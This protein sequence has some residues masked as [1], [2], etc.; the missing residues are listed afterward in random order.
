MC[1]SAAATLLMLCCFCLW[2]CCESRDLEKGSIRMNSQGATTFLAGSV[3]MVMPQVPSAVV[4]DGVERSRRLVTPFF[5]QNT[6]E[7][8]TTTTTTYPGGHAKTVTLAAIGPAASNPNGV[9]GAAGLSQ[10]ATIVGRITLSVT[11]SQGLADRPEFDEALARSIS[12]AGGTRRNDVIVTLAAIPPS[13]AEG[14]TSPA[15]SFALVYVLQRSWNP[16]L[17]IHAL[18]SFSSIAMSAVMTACLAEGLDSEGPVRL[19]TVISATEPI[20]VIGHALVTGSD[21]TGAQSV[22]MAEGNS[23][24]STALNQSRTEHSQGPGRTIEGHF[25]VIREN[26]AFSAGAALMLLC[27]FGCCMHLCSKCASQLHRKG[28]RTS[29]QSQF[30]RP[31]KSNGGT[32]EAFAEVDRHK[33]RLLQKSMSEAS[34]GTTTTAS[35][36]PSC[37][38]R[39]ETQCSYGTNHTSGLLEAE[40]SSSIADEFTAPSST[41]ERD[42]AVLP[43]LGFAG[44]T[45]HIRDR[46][47]IWPNGKCSPWS[48]HTL[49]VQACGQEHVARTDATTMWWDDLTWMN[50]GEEPLD[51]Y[52][53]TKTGHPVE[54]VGNCIIWVSGERSWLVLESTS[55]MSVQ[56]LDQTYK[57]TRCDRSIRWDDGDKWTRMEQAPPIIAAE[58][59]CGMILQVLKGSGPEKDWQAVAGSTV[60]ALAKSDE[61]TAQVMSPDGK[62]THFIP[63]SFLAAMRSPPP[64][65]QVHAQEDFAGDYELAMEMSP[66]GM[67]IWRQFNG[68]FWL[69]TSFD[70]RWCFGTAESKDA[71]SVDEAILASFHQ[72]WGTMPQNVSEWLHTTKHKGQFVEAKVEV[73]C[74]FRRCYVDERRPEEE[75][76]M[77]ALALHSP[78]RLYAPWVWQE[79]AKAIVIDSFVTGDGAMFCNV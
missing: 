73:N 34:L 23:T 74:V 22:G 45:V 53:I 8:F 56:V 9:G 79:W 55:D 18:S 69:Y 46:E 43:W 68:C 64:A 40:Y 66:S 75:N 76:M 39:E 50:I 31:L 12:L 62:C 41:S 65:L 77:K 51:G 72:H 4:P 54:V 20:V 57:G 42:Q 28:K 47:V 11:G 37:C 61:N 1:F 7:T 10:V 21:A 6:T 38:S 16:K 30:Q 44:H 36:N 17:A 25:K 78:P 71:A 15:G 60:L 14:Q 49:S 32:C 67:P 26:L 3:E 35:G 58:V 24:A 27:L 2:H 63:T 52:W 33:H 59:R 29:L 5:W 19:V 48:H 70:G 13:E